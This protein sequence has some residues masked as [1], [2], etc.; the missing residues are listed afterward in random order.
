MERTPISKVVLVAGMSDPGVTE[1]IAEAREREEANGYVL[2]DLRVT[3]DACAEPGYR[4]EWRI[5]LLFVKPDHAV[6][7]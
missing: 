4:P 2:V 6:M 3:T 5:A 7:V 1:K